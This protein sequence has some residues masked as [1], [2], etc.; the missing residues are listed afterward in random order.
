MNYKI[1]IQARSNSSR[2]PG[3]ML[4]PFCG[5][6]TILDIIINSLISV[7]DPGDVVLATTNN[8]SDDAL[9]EIAQKMNVKVFRGDEQDV[10]KRFIDSADKFTADVIVRVCADNP[11]LQAE[12]IRG[13]LNHFDAS[14]MDYL[15]FKMKDNTPVIK[16]H[17]GM[18]AEIVSISALKKVAQLT[19]DKTYR[20]HVTNYIYSNPDIFK[21]E[22][23]SLPY[24]IGRR[25]D[26]RLTIDT[27]EDFL[28]GQEI[29]SEIVPRT[30]VQSILNSID[31]NFDRI[32]CMKNQIVENSK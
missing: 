2:L 21:V 24:E 23:L 27:K 20:E 18:Y 28:L 26:V 31:L 3:K 1:I 5:N 15:S 17:L 25:N 6:Q 16:S 30:D 7:F 14:K 8:T 13:L 12:S 32:K 11:F 9:V 10:L 29:Y 4:M 22:F 19:T